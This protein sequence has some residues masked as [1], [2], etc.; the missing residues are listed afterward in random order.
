MYELKI[1]AISPDDLSGQ[2]MGLFG[3]LQEASAGAPPAAPAADVSGSANDA[4]AEEPKRRGRKPK[5][6]E[7]A[8]VADPVADVQA[9]PEPEEP[10]VEEAAEEPAKEL[11]LDDVRNRLIAYLSEVASKSKDPDARRT[12]CAAILEAVGREKISQIE[13]GD[14]AAVVR[15]IDALS[16]ALGQFTDDAAWVETRAAVIAEARG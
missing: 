11:T 16:G 5:A 8:A 3:L 7:P 12:D 14:F 10:T 1:T 9:Q 15:I 4:P 2:I 13:P 6:E